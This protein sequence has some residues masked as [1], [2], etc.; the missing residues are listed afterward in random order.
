MAPLHSSYLTMMNL[1]LDVSFTYINI[2]PYYTYSQTKTHPQD[3]KIDNL[4]KRSICINSVIASEKAIFGSALSNFDGFENSSTV[5]TMGSLQNYDDDLEGS[6]AKVAMSMTFVNEWLGAIS[7]SVVGIIFSQTAKIPVLSPIGRA[8]LEVDLAY[9]SNVINALGLRPHPL[10]VHT[11]NLLSTEPSNLVS[12]VD[13]LSSMSF[14][15]LSLLSYC[16]PNSSPC[17][18]TLAR[19]S[20]TGALKKYD[21]RLVESLSIGYGLSGRPA[22][23]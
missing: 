13:S 16:D 2:L 23:K 14:L 18:L 10:L 22:G 11:L 15:S 19:V 5:A 4:C 20:I 7:D 17:F 6:D 3:E 8:Q 12:S 1:P 21:K 9:V